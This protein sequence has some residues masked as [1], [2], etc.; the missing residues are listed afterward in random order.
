MSL[1][2]S[3]D[4]VQDWLQ[5]KGPSGARIDRCSITNERSDLMNLDYKTFEKH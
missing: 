4:N 3:P 2:A 5:T 1:N